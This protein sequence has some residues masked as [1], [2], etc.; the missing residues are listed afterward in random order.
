MSSTLLTEPSTTV[1]QSQQLSA[2]VTGLRNFRERG[3][4]GIDLLLPGLY[5]GGLRDAQDKEELQRHN[6]KF[7]VSILDFERSLTDFNEETHLVIKLSDSP[8]EN[9]LPHIPIVNEFIH[10]A[11][12]SGSNVLIHC[13]V[14]VSRSICFAAAYLLSCTKLSYPAAIAYI[15]SKRSIAKPNFG[16]RMQLYK[17]SQGINQEERNR[18]MN[19]STN[20]KA[21]DSQFY[22]DCLYTH[23]LYAPQP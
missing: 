5:V 17:F 9:I 19:L 18:L 1:N 14:G 7:I 13:L 21:F 6:I 12:L 23:T 15:E 20:S 16:F 22:D 10:R 11:R 8:Q 3:R 4:H 2:A